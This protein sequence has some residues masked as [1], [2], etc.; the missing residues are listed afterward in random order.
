MMVLASRGGGG[1]GEVG[2]EHTSNKV[3]MQKYQKN[4]IKVR[5]QKNQQR[6]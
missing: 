5:K 6:Q 3:V 1:G 2:L 4:L